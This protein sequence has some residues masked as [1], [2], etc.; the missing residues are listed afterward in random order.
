MSE[1]TTTKLDVEKIEAY[2]EEIYE[3]LVDNRYELDN[4]LERTKTADAVF[5]L[6]LN[7]V[8][9]MYRI[10][11]NYTTEASKEEII[12]FVT[13]YKDAEESLKMMLKMTDIMQG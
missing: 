1:F 6:A 7:I 11:L 2:F 8:D 12:E 3:F 9:L 13:A 10:N 4:T 5:K